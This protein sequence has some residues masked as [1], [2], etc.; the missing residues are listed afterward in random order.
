LPTWPH[1]AEEQAYG[2]IDPDATKRDGNGR[3]YRAL[4]VIG[5]PGENRARTETLAETASAPPLRF[6]EG[7]ITAAAGGRVRFVTTSTEG[8]QADPFQPPLV[9]GSQI[10]WSDPAAAGE[11]IFIA[12]RDAALYRLE[13]AAGEPRRL[14]AKREVALPAA[15]GPGLVAAGEL[16]WYAEPPARI[17][18][19][20]AG[21]LSVVGQRVVEGSLLW[22]PS[23]AGGAVLAAAEKDGVV[24]IYCWNEAGDF[25]KQTTVD[26]ADGRPWPPAVA[27]GKPWIST[28]A[29]A[30]LEINPA[31]GEVPG[32]TR[33]GTATAA[34]P[35]AAG[36][37]LVVL[38]SSG[39]LV[40][41]AKP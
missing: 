23:A 5:P 13:L 10:R 25:L 9:A 2:L 7:T 34:P 1:S 18:A 15:I 20:A 26:A 39:E 38:S 37:K 27:D 30:L 36:G 3:S 24:R 21:D 19:R 33:L 12:D 31:T 16:V 8:R 40:R 35:L 22:G 32:R 28:T 41:I 14:V 29:G 17:V 11:S 4:L 6:H